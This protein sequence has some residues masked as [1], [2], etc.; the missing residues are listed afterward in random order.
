MS[1]PDIPE[2][3]FPEP[4]A[5]VADLMR[6]EMGPR[7]NPFTM[8][9]FNRPPADPIC[10][11]PESAFPKSIPAQMMRMAKETRAKFDAL[12]KPGWRRDLE[13]WPQ[14]GSFGLLSDTPEARSYQRYMRADW[15]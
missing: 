15:P 9:E 8:P 1:Y 2:S 10:N 5:S 3:A 13:R 12:G 14:G 4:A 11:I 6:Q 7:Y